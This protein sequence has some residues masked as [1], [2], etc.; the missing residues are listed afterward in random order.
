LKKRYETCPDIPSLNIPDEWNCI[1]TRVTGPFVT[2]TILVRPDGTHVSW[3]SRFHRKHNNLLDTGSKSTW[4]APGAVSWWIGVLFA[5][6]AACFAVGSVPAYI[7]WVGNYADSMTYFIGSIFFTTAAFLQY[8][9]TINAKQA[10]K[11]VKLK[12]RIKLFTWEPRRIDWLATAIQFIGTI[13]FN[14][15]TFYAINLFMTAQQINNQIWTPDV[16]GSICFLIAS[17]L[18]WIEVGH[19]VFSFKPN[20]ISWQVAFLNL[21]GSIAFGVSA[22]SAFIIPVTGQPFDI[23]LESLGTFVGGLCFLFA[24]VLLLPER[25]SLDD[26][27]HFKKNKKLIESI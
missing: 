25:T 22:V 16:Y 5:I 15:S 18:V 14:F 17:G 6:G 19:G 24:A 4:W 20:F 13:F 10:L 9:E 21:L 8:S 26:R 23:T 1:K 7:N 11:G 2:G 3:K 12:E 27:I